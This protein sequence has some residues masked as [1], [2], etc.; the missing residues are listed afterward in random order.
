MLEGR[1]GGLMFAKKG[2]RE[3][4][5]SFQSTIFAHFEY[6]WGLKSCSIVSIS[7]RFRHNKI[8]IQTVTN[9]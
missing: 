2:R 7:D 9:Q 4:A 6:D 8:S 3:E 1:V 5:N